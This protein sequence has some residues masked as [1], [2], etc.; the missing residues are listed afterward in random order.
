M[1][2]YGNGEWQPGHVDPLTMD[3]SDYRNLSTW[4]R[5]LSFGDWMCEVMGT[6]NWREDA[7]HTLTLGE[8][9]VVVSEFVQDPPGVPVR[10]ADGSRVMT[11]RRLPCRRPPPV[12]KPLR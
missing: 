11:E 3:G 9:Y 12:W 6:V 4:D 2:W 8:G 1:S 10:G 7:I 5:A